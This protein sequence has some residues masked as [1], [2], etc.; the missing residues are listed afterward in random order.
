MQNNVEPLF[1]L[2]VYLSQAT[3]QHQQANER[4]SFTLMLCQ[5]WELVRHARLPCLH[6]PLTRID[7]LVR[8]AQ[9]PSPLVAR[10]RKKVIQKTFGLFPTCTKSPHSGIKLN[11]YAMGG[12]ALH[13]SLT[14]M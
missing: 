12:A 8:H 11:F 2:C 13:I 5:F 7:K 10:R 9:Q 3:S 6:M 4:T 14:V 1:C